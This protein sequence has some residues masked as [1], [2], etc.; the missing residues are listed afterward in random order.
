MYDLG[1]ASSFSNDL[2]CFELQAAG[3]GHAVVDLDGQIV[4]EFI[5]GFAFSSWM[6]ELQIALIGYEGAIVIIG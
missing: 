1:A 5:G 2:G 6:T 4:Y 3:C